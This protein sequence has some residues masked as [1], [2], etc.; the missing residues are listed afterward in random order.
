[1][2]QVGKLNS[3]VITALQ[4]NITPDTPIYI[5]DSNENH[6]KKRHPFEYDKYYDKIPDIISHPDYIGLNPKDQSIQY[7][8]EFKVD[9]EYI[10]VAI[11]ISN[12]NKCFV[13]TLHLLST[14]NAERY[15]QKGT[16]I[17]LDNNYK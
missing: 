2:R 7:V 16:L 17:K 1:M 6:I 14:Y 15:I 3:D 11:R 10:R 13:K 5:G 4:L 12:N 9:S 8:K